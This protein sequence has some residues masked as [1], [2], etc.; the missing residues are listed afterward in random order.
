MRIGRLMTVRVGLV[1]LTMMLAGGIA[2]SSTEAYGSEA[3]AGQEQGKAKQK[4][5]KGKGKC[6]KCGDGGDGTGGGEGGALSLRVT[7]EDGANRLQSDSPLR[8]S[9]EELDYVDGEEKVSA[10]IGSHGLS[11]SL[12]RGNQRAIR[13]LWV[14][15]SGDAC[16]SADSD[17]CMPP[18][19]APLDVS[20]GYTVATI[21]S[22]NVNLRAML[23]GAAGIRNDL[24]LQVV[25]KRWVLN[26]EPHPDC[27]GGTT[28]TV[29]RTA[30]DTWVIWSGSETRGCLLTR[31]VPSG[32]YD[33]PFRMTLTVLE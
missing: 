6:P 21:Y 31:G 22:S 2:A 18:D 29:E 13:K 10:A 25:M 20:S 16:V 17:D 7:I 23:E 24:G 28:A 15:F 11:L 14:D 26:F 5:G 33:M 12:T 30:E 8:L 3:Y 1:A 32:V 9:D 27:A 4:Q 19:Q